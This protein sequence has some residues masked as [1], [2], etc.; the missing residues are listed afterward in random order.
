MEQKK[1]KGGDV[2]RRE[3]EQRKGRGPGEG[4]EEGLE[5][6]EKRRNSVL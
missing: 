6:E 1:Q 5:T 3:E 4:T 2:R